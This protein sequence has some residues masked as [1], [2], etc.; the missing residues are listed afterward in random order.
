MDRHKRRSLSF[1]AITTFFFS[2][3]T[4]RLWVVFTRADIPVY[5]ASANYFGRNIVIGGI[6]VHHF[7]YGIVLLCVGGWIALVSEEYNLRK[8]AAVLYGAGLGFFI[9][10]VG[11]LLTWGEYWSSLTYA[12]IL[13]AAL[14]FVNAV[15][16]IDFWREVRKN[17]VLSSQSHPLAS[18]VLRVPLLIEVVDKL[19]G[20]VSRTE[21]VSIAFTG[22]VYLAAGVAVL[23][24]PRFLYYWVAGG[25]ILGGISQ[26]VRL[27]RT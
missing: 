22:L 6:H 8:L 5:G 14:A 21:K 23:I 12:V 3:L 7:M 15:Y 19:S 17:I 20:S 9:D 18:K 27:L 13:L 4:A 16:F 11:F 24:Y 25:F 1:I 26:F 2:F 10:E